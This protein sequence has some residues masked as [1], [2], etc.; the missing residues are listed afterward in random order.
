[1]ERSMALRKVETLKKEREEILKW[2]KQAQ[3]V[4]FI[5]LNQFQEKDTEREQEKQEYMATV[6]RAEEKIRSKQDAV[7]EY[8]RQLD[9]QMKGNY[10]ANYRM[11]YSLQQQK[12]AKLQ[13][14]EDKGNEKFLRKQAQND[15]LS[16]IN[17]L[18]NN[19][20]LIDENDKMRKKKEYDIELER[21][22]N[23][24]DKEE[25]GGLNIGH[26]AS[27][28]ELKMQQYLYKQTLLNQ[29]A[30]NEHN[31]HNFGKM[32]YAGNQLS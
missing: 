9:N 31:K 2:S 24:H 10:D 7:A 17:R 18:K 19:Q 21:I 11:V 4:F 29:H 32:T 20:I 15:D 16:Y 6:N 30:M 12:L 8:N 3:K 22:K 25:N 5:I 14:D 27:L 13:S 1:M 26:E 28:E 23:M